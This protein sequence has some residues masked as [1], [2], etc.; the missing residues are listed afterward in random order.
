VVAGTVPRD[1]VSDALF[2]DTADPYHYLRIARDG[3]RDVVILGGEDHKTGQHTNTDAC[4][5]R[6]ERG[7][8]SLV[9][10]I[11]PSHHWSGQ[12]IETPDGLPYIGRMADH[13]YA[14]TGFSGNGMTFGTVAAMIIADAILDR[15]N[16]WA[17]LFD[18]GRAALRRG[19]WEYIKEN[20][21]YPYYLVRDRFAGADTRSLRAVERGHGRIVEHNG[22]KVAAYRNTAGELTLRSAT[23]THMGCIVGWNDAEHSWD[24]PCHGSRFTPEGDVI[25]GPAESPLTRA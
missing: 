24:C 9:P 17:P 6:L 13:Q 20:A 10:G 22:H 19:M 25:S 12:V 23:C 5:E 4:Y 15:R 8:V 11:T 1:T 14:A 2:W 18:P 21:D 16:P 7:L 3:D